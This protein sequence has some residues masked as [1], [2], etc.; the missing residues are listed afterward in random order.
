[1]FFI[2][3]DGLHTDSNACCVQKVPVPNVERV[4]PQ[5]RHL[6]EVRAETFVAAQQLVS[7]DDD[8]FSPTKFLAGESTPVRRRRS[9]LRNYSEAND[10]RARADGTFAL[11]EKFSCRE[12]FEFLESD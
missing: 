12:N 2:S 8:T 7:R 1:M 4:T 11:T 9:L 3:L 5:K 6:S 10:F